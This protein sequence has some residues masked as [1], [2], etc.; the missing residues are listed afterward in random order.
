MAANKSV[1]KKA[2]VKP[3]VSKSAN[4]SKASKKPAEKKVKETKL[5]KVKSEKEEIPIE[6]TIKRRI[7]GHVPETYHFCLKDGTRL[8]S[9]H[10]L[11]VSLEDMPDEI[12]YHHVSDAKNDFANWVDDILKDHLLAEELR[13]VRNKAE[14]EIKLL[15]HVVRKM[16]D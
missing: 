3:Q 1:K 2:T 14:T 9:L 12:F 6:V 7:T 13:K 5:K 10:D 4:K 16:L 8:K 15:K 11:I